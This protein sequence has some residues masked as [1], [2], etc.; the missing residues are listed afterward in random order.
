MSIKKS[1]LQTKGGTIYH[2][3]CSFCFTCLHGAVPQ[4]QKKI[5]FFILTFNNQ[6]FSIE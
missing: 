1:A 3:I 2:I 5:Y 4:R 6:W